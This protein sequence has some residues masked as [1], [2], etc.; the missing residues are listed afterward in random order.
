MEQR[1]MEQAEGG[2]FSNI[3]EETNQVDNHN[4]GFFSGRNLIKGKLSKVFISAV[5]KD[6]TAIK[7]KDQWYEVNA[8]TKI[9]VGELKKGLKVNLYYSKGEKKN[10]ANAIYLVTDGAPVAAANQE[11][12]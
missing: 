6:G 8:K 2:L 7:V 3:S 10:F 9:D 12:Q 4:N 11:I 1:M 5:K